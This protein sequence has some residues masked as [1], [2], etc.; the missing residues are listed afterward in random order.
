MGRWRC[1]LVGEHGVG[2]GVN[3]TSAIIAKSIDRKRTVGIG[4][5]IGVAGEAGLCQRRE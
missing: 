3:G 1:A 2:R 5:G 4:L